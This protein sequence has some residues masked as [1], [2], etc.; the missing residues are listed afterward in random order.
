MY[1]GESIFNAF[2]HPACQHHRHVEHRPCLCRLLQQRQ[3]MRRGNSSPTDNT[4]TTFNLTGVTNASVQVWQENSGN[5]DPAN[6]G[7]INASGGTSATRSTPTRSRP[8]SSRRPARRRRPRASPPP[9]QCPSRPHLEHRLRRHQLHRQRGTTS[10]T[11]TNTFTSATNSYT[12]TGLTTR[13]HLLY[14]VS[15]TGSG[16]EKR[17]TLRQVSATPT[18][19]TNLPPSKRARSRP[20]QL[21]R[22]MAQPPPMP[23]QRRRLAFYDRNATN[24]YVTRITRVDQATARQAILSQ[25][26]AVRHHRTQPDR[27]GATALPRSAATS[28]PTLLGRWR[29]ARYHDTCR[30]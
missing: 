9:G 8:S 22:H 25:S 4:A 26:C 1:T 3:N 19:G 11:Y 7:T 13:H 23:T 24:D 28:R 16:G 29:H 10:G 30:R 20:G 18:A 12:N 27:P 6:L 17:R 2:G 15:A 14:V 5:Q 21:R